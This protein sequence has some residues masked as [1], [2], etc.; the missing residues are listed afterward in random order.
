MNDGSDLP[1][2]SMKG[3]ANQPGHAGKRESV[4]GENLVLSLHAGAERLGERLNQ[5]TGA[6]GVIKRQPGTV[7]IE[8]TVKGRSGAGDIKER[9]TNSQD[10]Q[11]QV[12]NFGGVGLHEDF[13]AFLLLLTVIW[14]DSPGAAI[15]PRILA[16]WAALRAVSSILP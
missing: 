13:K 8:K 11:Q 2:T 5:E 16:E 9:R 10:G 12:R 14:L 7:S 4:H 15:P 1:R 3:L 6:V